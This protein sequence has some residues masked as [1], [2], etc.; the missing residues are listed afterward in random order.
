M[1]AHSEGPGKGSVFSFELPGADAAQQ[2]ARSTRPALVLVVDDNR[3]AADSLSELLRLLGYRVSAAY[4]GD[5]ALAMATREPPLAVFLDLN[6]PGISGRE[7]LTALREMPDCQAAHVTAV[8]GY[9]LE[10]E[11]AGR[12]NFSGFDARL[13]KPVELSALRSV[14]TSA[15][16]PRHHAIAST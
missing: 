4:D 5:T 15:A 11:K 8:S 2:T 13:Q 7:V 14:L 16:F 9:G 10:D 12:A 6:M 1:T 3:D